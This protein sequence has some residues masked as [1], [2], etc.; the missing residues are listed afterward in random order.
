LA[1]VLFDDG[2]TAAGLGDDEN[3][4]RADGRAILIA[5]NEYQLDRTLELDAGWQVDEGTVGNE[6]G[7]EGGERMVVKRSQASEVFGDLFGTR[8][9][10]QEEVRN[11]DSVREVSDL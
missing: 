11:D 9:G 2:S 7:V 4:W 10:A 1:E 3:A 5:R 6:S 8:S